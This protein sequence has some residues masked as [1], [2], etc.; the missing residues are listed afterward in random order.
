MPMMSLAQCMWWTVDISG[1][2]ILTMMAKHQVHVYYI[3]EVTLAYKKDKE[4]SHFWCIARVDFTNSQN[5]KNNGG[6]HAF[7]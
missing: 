7:F 4:F 2:E 1:L 5:V 3:K 6:P